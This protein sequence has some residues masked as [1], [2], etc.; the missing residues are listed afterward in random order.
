MIR[1]LLLFFLIFNLS[2]P[3]QD[4]AFAR[5]ILKT[6]CSQ[7]FSGRGYVNKGVDKAADYL[8]QI[9]KGYG[10]KPLNQK[11]YSQF[12][13]STI[14]TFPGKMNV[15][16]DGKQLVPG[17]HYIVSPESKSLKGTY[18]LTKRDSVTY[19]HDSPAL[20]ISLQKKLTWSVSII[21]ENYTIV[22]LLKDSFPE[23][24]KQLDIQIENKLISNYKLRNICGYI[25]GSEKPDSFIVFSAHYDH[26][27]K[28]GANTIFPG[29]NDN[30][31]GTAMLLSLM[32]YYAMPEHKPK[33]SIAFIGFS[34]EEAGLL[35]SAYF[36]N[37]PL[38]P[39]NK[40]KFLINLDLLGTGDE[41]ITVVNATEFKK[42][43]NSLKELNEQNKYLPLVKPRGKAR[44]SD[45]YWFSEKGVPCFFIY[46]MG[47]I[48]AYHDVYDIERTLP[49]TKFKE[50]FCLL[51]DFSGSLME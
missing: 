18:S 2:L 48:K 41:G 7:K 44:N 23:G 47:G 12:Y 37:N 24:I 14:N 28:M 43:F 29:A 9:F 13:T 22:E 50:V 35:G 32:R 19:V 31:S 15:K 45:H 38:I 40:I 17:V 25:P 4:T 33:C 30:A 34:A 42:E 6:L 49:L 21:Q 46:T 1:I 8:E 3:A 36:V 5:S 16:A 11:S 39:L 26:L 20:M 10:L 27:G 51:R